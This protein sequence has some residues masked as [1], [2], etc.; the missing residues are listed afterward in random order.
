MN[1]TTITDQSDCRLIGSEETLQPAPGRNYCI[2]IT[3]IGTGW[4]AIENFLG[5]GYIVHVLEDATQREALEFQEERA[6]KI[7]NNQSPPPRIVFCGGEA[8]N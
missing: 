4:L 2:A 8:A 3:A 7:N 5:R 1:V 6:N